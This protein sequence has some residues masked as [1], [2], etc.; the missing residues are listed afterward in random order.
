MSFSEIDCD[1]SCSVSD[2]LWPQQRHSR[3][4]THFI[5]QDYS[6]VVNTVHCLKLSLQLIRLFALPKDPK[7]KFKW[8]L[9]YL[10][11]KS[12]VQIKSRLDARWSIWY[13]WQFTGPLLTQPCESTYSGQPCSCQAR[14]LINSCASQMKCF[15]ARSTACWQLEGPVTFQMGHM[16]SPDIH[17]LKY[18]WYI[19]VGG[20]NERK[21]RDMLV[22]F[23]S[24]WTWKGYI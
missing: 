4:Q 16:L 19:Y 8:L 10:D 22:D 15:G 12:I 13:L 6:T 23:I 5:K 3:Q 2:C 24:N 20:S 14:T 1:Y 9:L 18:L 17:P 11:T 7:A 21:Q